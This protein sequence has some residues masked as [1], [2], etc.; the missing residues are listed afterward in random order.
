MPAF[1]KALPNFAAILKAS[2]NVNLSSSNTKNSLS[3]CIRAKSK[4]FLKLSGNEAY[5]LVIIPKLFLY[6]LVSKI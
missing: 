4:Y 1:I 2:A 5:S 3:P 6:S